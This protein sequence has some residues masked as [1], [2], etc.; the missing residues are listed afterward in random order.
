M[1]S[2]NER[3]EFSSWGSEA[4]WID[5]AEFAPPNLVEGNVK[6]LVRALQGEDIGD[7]PLEGLIRRR[8]VKVASALRQ[9]A[10][11]GHYPERCWQL[12]L[13]HLQG[14]TNT[15]KP[16]ARLQDC[17]A[18]VL[19]NAPVALFAGVD[20]AA[21]GFVVNLAERYDIDRE[22]NLLALWQKAW[23]GAPEAKPNGNDPSDQVLTNATGRLAEAALTRLWKYEPTVQ[24][25][26]PAAVRPYFD[27]IASDPKGLWGRFNLIVRL[28]DLYA[29]DPR[30]TREHLLSRLDPAQ[31]AA[32][33]YTL[34]AAYALS[35][36]V[37]PDLLA[38]FKKPFLGVLK[39]LD[40]VSQRDRHRLVDLFV[41]ICLEAP[42]ELTEEE[43]RDVVDSLAD[44]ELTAVLD[45]LRKRLNGDATERAQIWKIGLLPWLRRYWP[46]EGARNTTATSR[47]MLL[48]L[49][50]CGD[51]FSDAVAEYSHHLRPGDQYSLYTLKES[52][53]VSTYPKPFFDILMHVLGPAPIQPGSRYLVQEILDSLKEALPGLEAE[54]DFRDMYM[55]AT[56]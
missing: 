22:P 17:V 23:E 13:W 39:T 36:K 21:A 52:A 7:M 40:K 37:G 49:L 27:N 14:R 54:P 35:P 55:R 19:A 43:V 53:Y 1:E 47:E 51:S 11:Q 9:L 50:E 16:T 8:P 56:S 30:W 33:T 41:V 48:L 10:D 25:T 38:A 6:E 32:E 34:W 5:P 24:G 44:D 31:Q 18:R 42:S 46:N 3:D 26:L 15:Q 4:R 2:D 20:S 45:S 12:F 28:Y 29:I